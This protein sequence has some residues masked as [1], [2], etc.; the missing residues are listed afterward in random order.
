MKRSRLRLFFCGWLFVLAWL[1][2]AWGQVAGPRVNKII[3]RHVGPPAVSDDFIRANIRIK[4]GEPFTRIA[5]DEDVRTLY[6]TGYFFKI[7]VTEDTTAEGVDLTYL[8]QGKP[9]LTD[10]KIVGNKKVSLKKLKKKITSKVGQPLDERKIFD[11]AQAMRE[12]YEK[13]GYQKTTV[14]AEPPVI[15]EMAG[16]GT[17]MFEIHETPK[18]RIKNVVFVNA[19]L[20]QKQLRKVLKTRRRWMFS[21]LT[22]SGVL[23]EDQFDDDKE[24]LIEFYQNKGYI[25]FA[26][27]DVKIDYLSPKWMDVSIV[28]SE[29]RRY[30]VGALDIKGNKLF[31]T[32]DFIKGIKLDKQLMKLKLRPGEIFTPTAFNDDLETLTDMYGSKGYLS[33][34]QGG[35]TTITG[36]HTANPATGTIDVSY[37]IDEGE[38]C[39]IEKIIIKGNVKTKDKVLRRELAVY[40]GEV[41]D[42]VRVKI[43]KSKLEQMEYFE[44]VD[45]QSQDT[46]VPNRKDLVIGVEEKS[47]GNVTVG[48]GFS[49]IE[50]IVGFVELKQGDFDLFNPPTFTGA[51]QKFQVLASVGTELQDYEVSFVEPWFLGERLRLGVD[52]FHRE[53]DYNSI[54]NMYTETFDG[55]TISLTKAL[56]SQFL[57]GSISYT[58]EVAHV[59]INQGFSTNYI[60]T[61][62]NPVNGSPIYQNAAAVS[63]NLSTN[64]YD[65]HGT[66]VINKIGLGLTYDTRNNFRLPDRGQESQITAEVAT[67]PGDTEFYKLELHSSWFF[68]G[69]AKG[70][71]IELDGRTG[72]V[73]AWGASTH[74]PIFERWFLG[75]L[76]SLR[77]Y[78]YE[79][80]GPEDQFGEP[81]GGDTYFF[82]SA[83]Y[84]IPIIKMLRVAAFYDV[85]NVYPDP[86][87]FN[88]GPNRGLYS[89]DAGLGLRIVL[90][91]GGGTPLRLD[92]GI[93]ITHDPNM[94]NSG[95]FQFGVGYQHPF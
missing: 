40:P 48:A 18:V 44:K 31:T 65:E 84:S 39:Y 8:V 13:M 37:D 81:L 69:F 10:I 49:T 14:T 63:P 72:V 94:G 52:L 25:D 61:Y 11:D 16:R 21:W 75:G 9:I 93:P 59:A 29:G 87:S 3:I 32:N 5:A 78:R 62:S 23:K 66:Y 30:K 15:D 27:Q 22:G 67:R 76:Y 26:I 70:H 34:S 85:G 95:K 77:G 83:E 51:G 19:T 28:V 43:S 24:K 68:P 41:Y 20:P 53:I 42:M 38:K 71:I 35:T 54:N 6:G 7:Q 33:R 86:F 50:S 58:P 46:D 89:D 1:P 17:V 4:V 74:V 91:I 12:L 57:S 92:Y 55:A 82:G 60:P 73:S 88:P 36:D 64:I 45:T 47:T 2:A 90:P 79:T 80:V 56:W